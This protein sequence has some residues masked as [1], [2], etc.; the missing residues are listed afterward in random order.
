MLAAPLAAHLALVMHRGAALA[1][2]L[3]AV[4]AVIVTWI[5]SSSIPWR[6]LRVCACGVIFLCVLFLSRFAGG[7][8]LVASAVPHAIAYLGL[9]AIFA[10]SLQPGREAVLTILARKARGPLPATVVRYTRRVTWS[11]C[12]FFLA[13]LL[14]SFLLLV[15]ARPE[16][17]SLFINLFNLPLIGV[18]FC[19]EYTYRQWRHA[20]RSPERLVDMLQNIRQIRATPIGEDR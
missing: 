15:F 10:A 2:I 13:Q 1:S 16:V 17:W 3:V 7:D 18:M 14:A 9:L 12:W 5:A 6:A 8:L 4:Q 11:W 19:A 20:G